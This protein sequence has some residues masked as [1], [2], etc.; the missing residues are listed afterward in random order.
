MYAPFGEPLFEIDKVVTNTA[1]AVSSARTAG[2]PVVFTRHQYQPGHADF[3]RLFPQYLELLRARGGLLAG[4]WDV[5]VIEELEPGPNDLMIDK[6]RLDAF[7]GTSLQ[8]LLHG[9]GV[10]HIV[11]AGIMTNACVETTTRSAAMRDYEVTLLSDCT[12]SQQ[13]KHRDMSLEGLAA[14]HLATVQPFDGALFTGN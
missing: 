2:V 4:T 5:D 9:L 6:P 14:Y 11:I 8:T 1:I 3:G 7:H 12:T 10:S 13:E